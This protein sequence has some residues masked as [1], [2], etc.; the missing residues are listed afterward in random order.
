VLPLSSGSVFGHEDGDG[1]T[2]KR[3]Y[4]SSKLDVATSQKAII[5]NHSSENFKPHTVLNRK[6]VILP[7]YRP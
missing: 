6:K 5:S 1:V 7:L 2:S 3:L 4:T